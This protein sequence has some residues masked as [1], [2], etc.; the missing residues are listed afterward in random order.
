MIISIVGLSGS[1]K[2][3][4]A[5]TL[6]NYSTHIIHIDIDKIG[7][8]S[9]QDPQV[10]QQLIETFG[11]EILTNKEIDRKKLG[12]IVFSSKEAMSKLEDITW[13]FM[14]KE[15]DKIIKENKDKIILL[16][17]LLLPR[18]K[19]FYKSDFR[20]LVK[21]PLEVRMQRAIKRDNITPEKFL[22]RESSAPE[23]DE[24]KF[25][26]IINNINLNQ[27]QERIKDIY[28]KSIIHR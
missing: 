22:L 11:N 15:I 13:S 28:D 6:E 23:I 2:S 26:Y 24:T 18:T 21:A 3:I 16:D 27:T 12:R 19:Y 10:K 5:Q 1:G 17:W 9:H 25:E 7:H 14:E 20:I 8:L 4:I